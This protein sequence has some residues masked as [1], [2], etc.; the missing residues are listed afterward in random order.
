MSASPL[1]RVRLAAAG[2]GSGGERDRQPR[3][4]PRLKRTLAALLLPLSLIPVLLLAPS[5][6]RAP[7]TLWLRAARFIAPAHPRT[8]H[9]EP[10][11]PAYFLVGPA[12]FELEAL[13]SG[14][15]A[16]T[17]QLGVSPLAEP[18]W[19]AERAA[20]AARPVLLVVPARRAPA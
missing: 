18:A 4:R 19:A 6:A 11:G 1:V 15:G 12:R 2:I 10:S 17:P 20:G 7:A 16:L 8:R 13:R 3:V 5:L 14:A 9:R